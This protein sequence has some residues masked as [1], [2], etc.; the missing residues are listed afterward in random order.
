MQ[1][2]TLLN[3]CMGSTEMR[4]KVGDTLHIIDLALWINIVIEGYAILGYVQ[5]KRGI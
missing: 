4:V 5:G 2:D 1:I 3:R